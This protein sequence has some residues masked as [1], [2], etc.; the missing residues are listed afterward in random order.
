MTNNKQNYSVA[1]K[2]PEDRISN[3]MLDHKIDLKLGMVDYYHD[4]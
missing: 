4:I 1:A 2:N 3:Y